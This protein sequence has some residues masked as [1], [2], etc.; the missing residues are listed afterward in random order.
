MACDTVI[1]F[2]HL[3]HFTEDRAVFRYA[4]HRSEHPS[5]FPRLLAEAH[6]SSE[7]PNTIFTDVKLTFST[8]SLE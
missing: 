7:Q 1:P 3:S 5:I 8:H 2:S 6:Y 4:L